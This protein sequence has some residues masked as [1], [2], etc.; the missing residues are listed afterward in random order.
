MAATRAISFANA[1]NEALWRIILKAL[2][3]NPCCILILE[4]P[5]GFIETLS[6]YND[7]FVLSF[8]LKATRFYRCKLYNTSHSKETI[9]LNNIT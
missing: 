2:V 1:S 3:C 8:E 6:V 5:A 9:I 7:K 4:T